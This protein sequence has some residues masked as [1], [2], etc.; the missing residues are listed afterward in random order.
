MKTQP[1]DPGPPEAALA[2]PGA[3][4]RPFNPARLLALG[5]PALITA[6]IVAFADKIE[7]LTALGYMGAFLVM[8]IGNATVVFPVPG[9]IFIFALGSALNP[10][11]VALCA[12]PGAAIGEMS[13]YLAGFGG[14]APV[15]STAL[16]RRFEVWMRNNG[17]L[18][19]F[20]L[21]AIPNPVFDLA[22]IMAGAS[23]MLPW[24]FLLAAWAGKTLQSAFIA[25][26]GYYSIGWVGQWL[27]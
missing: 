10:W 27:H 6:L 3:E 5:A 21:S 23:K 4:K 25:L 18:T 8:L 16:A 12:G 20:L 22:G 13:G 24:K 14:V 15:E 7:H 26:A 19:V 11:L 2:R 1:D 9:L 17:M